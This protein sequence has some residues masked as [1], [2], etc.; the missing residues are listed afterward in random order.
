M[1]ICL[2][3]KGKSIGPKSVK[4]LVVDGHKAVIDLAISLKKKEPKGIA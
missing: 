4:D 3:K 1:R 2:R